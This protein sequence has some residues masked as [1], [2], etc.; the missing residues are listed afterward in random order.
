MALDTAIQRFRQRQESLFRSECTVTRPSTETP[1]LNE[2]TGEV[3][4]PAGELIYEGRCQIRAATVQSQ[5][6]EAGETLVRLR[7]LVL[8]LPPNT[9]VQRNDI[10]S[11]IESEHDEG[12]EGA[13]FRITDVPHDDWQIAR[14]AHLEEQDG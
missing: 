4:S 1:V 7:R 14:V 6:V 2:E 5:D 12:L 11:I 8:K 9:S 10:V 13:T 3:E